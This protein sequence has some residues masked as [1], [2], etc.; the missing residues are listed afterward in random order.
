[1]HRV[2]RAIACINLMGLVN[3]FVL[4]AAAGVLVEGVTG[5]EPEAAAAGYRSVFL[6]VAI[7]LMV[8]GSV[9][10]RVRDVPVREPA[11]A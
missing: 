6:L 4:Q 10:T 7:V 1:V 11:D 5:G 9:Y 8:A 3:V 2:G